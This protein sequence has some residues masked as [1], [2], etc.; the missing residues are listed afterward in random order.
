MDRRLGQRNV[1]MSEEARAEKRFLFQ[2]RK[3]AEKR[4]TALG[5]AEDGKGLNL[6]KKTKKKF[7]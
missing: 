3:L 4:T 7:S 1:E 5:S 2:Q 6:F